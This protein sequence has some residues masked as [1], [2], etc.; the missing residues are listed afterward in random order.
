[1]RISLPAVVV[2]RLPFGIGVDR[3]N[4]KG[5]FGGLAGRKWKI[6]F[7]LK[8]IPI[9]LKRRSKI[10]PGSSNNLDIV[11]NLTGLFKGKLILEVLEVEWLGEKMLFFEG[12]LFDKANMFN[13]VVD[14]FVMD[15]IG[16]ISE[17]IEYFTFKFAVVFY[18]FYYLFCIFHVW[19]FQTGL[20]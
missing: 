5:N 7:L 11:I 20:V 3:I 14:T 19:V 16:Y 8:V 1:M 12:F 4:V 13:F 10:L 15:D 9:F 17:E 6:L 18:Y 2:W